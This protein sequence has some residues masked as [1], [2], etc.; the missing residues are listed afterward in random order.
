M[1]VT[2]LAVAVAGSAFELRAG[3]E[4]PRRLADRYGPFRAPPRPGGWTFELRAGPLPPLSGLTGHAVARD[5]LLRVGGA[6]PLGSLDPVAR[7][8]EALAD[9][10][11]LVVDALVRAAV[12]LDV[13]A[14]GGCLLHAAAVVVDGEAHLFPGRSGEGKSTLASLAGFA[15]SDELCAVLPAADGDGFL[16]HGTPWWVGRPGPAPLAAVHAI[17]W[18]GEGCSPLPRAGALR[19]LA[20]SLVLPVDGPAERA[21]AFAAAARIAAAVL[22]RRFAFRPGSDV[23]ALLRRA[24]EAA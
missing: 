13:A 16:V 10:S 8:A 3:D 5:G 17:A 2:T 14:R 6:E 23:D 15:L 9:P 19:R 24:R 18:D 1:T 11:L 20:S 12:A 7:R 4:A 21:A 22:F